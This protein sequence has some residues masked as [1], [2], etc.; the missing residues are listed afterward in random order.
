MN[1]IMQEKKLQKR[2]TGELILKVEPI[3]LHFQHTM[4]YVEWQKFYHK[5]N[6]IIMRDN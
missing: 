3:L 5:T 4:N 6:K 2:W 1:D